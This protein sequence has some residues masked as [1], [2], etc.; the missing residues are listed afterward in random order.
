MKITHRPVQVADGNSA[1]LSSKSEAA[2][3]PR[4]SAIAVLG[5]CAVCKV[6]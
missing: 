2:G 6:G 1:G 3:K 4:G 5:P